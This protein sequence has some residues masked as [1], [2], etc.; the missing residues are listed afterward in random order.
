MWCWTSR[1]SRP[2]EISH[3]DYSP[4]YNGFTHTVMPLFG[5]DL[6]IVTDECIQDDGEDWPKPTW[7]FDMRDERNP[8]PI[9]TL[10]VPG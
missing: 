7:V 8:V 2:K 9:S 1:Q 6:L 10:P 4:P 5:S 3:Y